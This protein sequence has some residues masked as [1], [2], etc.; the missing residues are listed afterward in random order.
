MSKTYPEVYYS[1]TIKKLLSGTPP[2]RPKPEY[3][4]RPENSGS[5]LNAILLWGGGGSFI[6]GVIM[7]ISEGEGAGLF[8]VFGVIAFVLSLVFTSIGKETREKRFQNSPVMS[9]Y[10]EALRQWEIDRASFM[11]RERLRNYRKECYSKLE[12]FDYHPSVLS[13]LGNEEIDV[14]KGATESFFISALDS[15][16]L[17]H[18]HGPMHLSVYHTYYPDIV[19][20]SLDEKILFDIEIDEPYAFDAH[21]PIHYLDERGTSIDYDRNIAFVS[22]GF[23]V[24]RFSEE[25]VIRFTKE[26]IDYIQLILDSIRNGYDTIPIPPHVL[27]Q[28]KWTYEEARRM[29]NNE[30]R[31]SYLPEDLQLKEGATYDRPFEH[32]PP[33]YADCDDLPF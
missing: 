32:E 21:N 6:V 2:F 25:E 18:I 16:G 12:R 7:A 29:A 3:P 9:Q 23:C 30:F 20:S 1:N 19:I 22:H 33:R 5:C 14:L 26:C 28:D 13:D 17:F 4:S 11:T 31:E 15:S 10:K 24:I 8:I 27:V